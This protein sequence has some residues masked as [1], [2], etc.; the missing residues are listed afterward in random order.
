MLSD[1]PASSLY[2]FYFHIR[3]RRRHTHLLP[4]FADTAADIAF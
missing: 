1:A 3:R 2:A 4:I